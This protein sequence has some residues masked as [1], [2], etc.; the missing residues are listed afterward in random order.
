M[1]SVQT[2]PSYQ[3][4]QS[5]NRA[6]RRT[7]ELFVLNKMTDSDWNYQPVVRVEP[8]TGYAKQVASCAPRRT[9]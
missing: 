9:P 2:H 3:P 6:G 7:G 1:C 4:A 5:H 8:E